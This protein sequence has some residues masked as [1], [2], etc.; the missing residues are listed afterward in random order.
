MKQPLN[1]KRMFCGIYTTATFLSGEIIMTKLHQLPELP[2]SLDALE[3]YISEETLKYHHGKHHAGYVNKLN[4]AVENTEFSGKTLEQIIAT[5]QGNIFNNAAQ[6]WN[7]SFYWQCLSAD[8]TIDP[9]CEI[10]RVIERDFGG[11]DDF[12]QRFTDTA[13]SLFGSGWTWL[14]LNKEG[15]IEIVNTENAG[16][17]LRHGQIPLLTCDVWEHAYYLDYKNA[18]PDYLQAFWKLVNWDF[19]N[20]QYMTAS[21]ACALHAAN[22]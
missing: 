14:V 22:Q 19:V 15:K 10:I 12:K 8:N 3:P 5:A 20:E 18:R 17:P 6:A 11:L 2:Y 1:L 7:H 16:T 9:D 13:T 4:K 21:E